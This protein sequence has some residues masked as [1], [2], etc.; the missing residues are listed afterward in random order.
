M[1]QFGISE[2]FILV[3]VQNERVANIYGVVQRGFGM[4]PQQAE[5]AIF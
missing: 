3:N 1:F 4:L 5:Q 2:I